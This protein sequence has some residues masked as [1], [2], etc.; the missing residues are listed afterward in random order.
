MTLCVMKYVVS[1]DVRVV[2]RDVRMMACHVRVMTCDV[3]VLT[4]DVAC[5]MAR[6]V[7]CGGRR[8]MCA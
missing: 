2:A 5:E 8:M 4:R 1:C 6:T 3:R 7:A